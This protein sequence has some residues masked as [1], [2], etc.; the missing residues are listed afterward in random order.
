MRFQKKNIK[1]YTKCLRQAGQKSYRL[2]LETLESRYLL[3]AQP[4]TFD[5]ELGGIGGMDAQLTLMGDELQLLN[6]GS[7]V[8]SRALADT[9]KIVVLGSANADSLSIDASLPSGVPIE[10]DGRGG[11]D[12]LIGSP[13]FISWFLN[14]AG[15]GLVDGR[16]VFSNVENLDASSSPQSVLNYSSFANA[17]TVNL[18]TQSSTGLDSVVGFEGVIGSPFNDTITGSPADEIFTG[19]EGGDTIDGDGGEDILVEVRDADFT[20]TN[21]RLTVSGESPDTISDIEK[22]M[23]TGGPGNNRLDASSSS[24]V[25]ALDGADGDDE[26]LGGSANDSLTGGFG[27]DDINGGGGTDELVEFGDGRFV[28]TD[29]TLDVGHGSNEVQ[30]ISLGGSA[31]G[32]FR[33]TYE[34]KSTRSLTTD[35][36]AEGI[37]SALK[38]LAGIGEQDISVTAGVS[39]QQWSVEFRGNLAGS[40]V[41]ELLIDE[42]QLSN[43]TPVA[44]SDDGATA[45]EPFTAIEEVRLTGGSNNNQFDLHNYTGNVSVK[46]GEGDDTVVVGN[47]TFRLDGGLGIDILEAS[48]GNAVLK[49]AALDFGNGDFPAIGFERAMLFGS[50][51][52]DNLDATQFRGLSE[53]TWLTQLA[54]GNLGLVSGND[55][56]LNVNGESIELDLSNASMIGDVVKL[57]SE[58]SPAIS[59]TFDGENAR[60]VVSSTGDPATINFGSINGSAAAEG[61]GLAGG[62][63]DAGVLTGSQLLG[64]PSVKIQGLGGDDQIKGSPGNDF[65]T[66]NSGSDQITGGGGIDTFVESYAGISSAQFPTAT[67]TDTSFGTGLPQQ[68]GTDTLAGVSRADITLGQFASTF[69]A[70]GFTLGPVVV[71][72][73]GGADT[74]IGSPVGT[75]FDIDTMNL[76]AGETVTVRPDQAAANDVVIRTGNAIGQGDL[77]RVVYDPP[78][79]SVPVTLTNEGCEFLECLLPLTVASD[80]SAPGQDVTLRADVVQVFGGT[81]DTSD[82]T[83]AGNIAIK[84]HE[85]VLDGDATLRAKSA[86]GNDGKIELL[87]TD[88]GGFDFQGALKLDDSKATIIT[89]TTTIEGG[90]VT[91]ASTAKAENTAS[92]SFLKEYPLAKLTTLGFDQ[93]TGLIDGLSL[94]GAIARAEAFAQVEIGTNTVIH[95]NEFVASSSLVAAASTAPNSELFDQSSPA[96]IGIGLIETH[97]EIRVAGTI[98]ASGNATISS[99]V[100]QTADVLAEGN[101]N[102]LGLSV[103]ESDSIVEILD[104]AMLNVGSDLFVLADTVDHNRTASKAA[105]ADNP[106]Q[107][108]IAVSVE[109]G[110]TTLLFDG[111]ANVTGN[112]QASANQS[113]VG[114][115]ATN[116]LVGPISLP[117]INSGVTAASVVGPSSSKF[118]DNFIETSIQEVDEGTGFADFRH[119]FID[120]FTES[121]CAK[122]P[123]RLADLI[124]P[125]DGPAPDPPETPSVPSSLFGGALAIVVDTNNVRTR[126]GDGIVRPEVG[127]ADL[128]AGGMFAA[129]SKISNRPSVNATSSVGNLKL[130]DEKPPEQSGE[131]NSFAVSVGIFNNNADTIIESDADIDAVGSLTVRADTI[132]DFDPSSL[133]GPFNLPKVEDATYTTDSGSVTVNNGDTVDV[134]EGHKAADDNGGGNVGTRYKYAGTTRSIDLKTANFLDTGEWTLV[135]NPAGNAAKSFASSIATVLSSDLGLDSNVVDTWTQATAKGQTETR[136]GSAIVLSMNHDADAIVRDG[137]RINQDEAIA[138]GA[139]DVVV[140]ASS[141][142]ELIN[143]G[144]NISTPGL[145]GGGE[146]FQSWTL[147]T[148]FSGPGLGSSSDETFSAIGGAIMVFLYDDDV[149]ARIE[150]GAQVDAD[151][152]YVDA[153]NTALAVTF[154]AAGGESMDSAY[155]GVV[156]ANSIDN[157]TIAQVGSGA[158][159][160]IRSKNVN[161]GADRGAPLVIEATDQA[162]VVAI[163]GAVSIS[164]HIGVGATVGMNFVTRDTEAILG[165]RGATAPTTLG[166][167]NVA[168]NTSVLATND[169]FVGALAVSGAKTGSSG[170]MSSGKTGVSDRNGNNV[171]NPGSLPTDSGESY[172]DILGDIHNLFEEAP[173]VTNQG[174]AG[175]GISGSVTLNVLNQ[176]A[177][178]VVRNTGAITTQD[179]NVHGTDESIV[180]SLAG[181]ATFASGGGTGGGGGKGISGALGLNFMGGTTEAIVDATS[182]INAANLDIHAM[183]DGWVVSLT[184]GVAGAS[185][186]G[187][188]A[189]GG[190]VS[191]TRTTNE[192]NALL[193]DTNGAVTG[194]AKVHAMDA[195]NVI[196]IAGSAGFGSRG[197]IGAAAGFSELD[198][199]VSAE[200]VNVGTEENPFTFNDL[201][202]TAE[203]TG[204][205][206]SVTGS[207][208]VATNG[209][210]VG[211]TLSINVIGNEIGA[212]VRNSHLTSTAGDISVLATDD[213]SIFSFAGGLAAG[214]TAGLGLAAAINFL[215]NQVTVDM[216]DSVVRGG[217]AFRVESKQTGMIVSIAVGGALANNI[218][219]GGAVAVNKTNNT[220]RNNLGDSIVVVGGIIDVAAQDQTASVNIAGGAAI[221]GKAALGVGVSVNL[222]GNTIETLV[223]G[224]KLESTGST[225]TVRS[226]T[227]EI[228]VGV[229]VG[230]SG[231][232]TAALAGSVS[233]NQISNTVNTKVHNNSDLDASGN[234]VISAGDSTTMVVVAGAGALGGTAGF[235]AAVGTTQVDNQIFA[236]IDGSAVDSTG[237]SVQ[238]LAGFEAPDSDRDV[239]QIGVG[240]AGHGIQDP[241]QAGK[242]DGDDEPLLTST[243]SHIIN[244]AVA[245][246]AAGT[247]AGGA[248]INLNWLKNHV[249]ASIINGATVNGKNGVDVLANDNPEIISIAIGVA[250]AGTGAGGGAISYNYIGGNPGNP[251]R[252]VPAIPASK[253]VGQVRA[254]IANSTVSSSDD[255]VDVKTL[256][257]P[258]IINVSVGVAAAGAA[259]VGGSIS[260]N[261][262]R[263]I[264]EARIADSTVNAQT[265]A[266]VD[267][268]VSPSMIIVAGSGAGSG[269]AAAAGAAATNDMRNDVMAK[270]ENSTVKVASDAGNLQVHATVGPRT[271]LSA[272]NNRVRLN[273]QDEDGNQRQIDTQIWSFAVSG[274]GA[275]GAAAAG[276]LALNWIRNTV[277]AH[278]SGGDTHEIESTNVSVAAADQASIKSVAGAGSGAGGAAVG[279]SVA[280]NYIGGNPEDPTS[281]ERNTVIA[282]IHGVKVIAPTV[283]VLADSVS[284]INT[285]SI[286]GAGAGGV[287]ASGGLSLNFIRTTLDAH[288]SDGA[289]VN[290]TGDIIVQAQDESTIESLSVAGAVA[291]GLGAGAAAAYNEIQ[292]NV[293]ATIG[294]S[295]IDGGHN[296]FVHALSTPTIDVIVAGLGV[297]AVGLA[298][299]GS[300]NKMRSDVRASVDGADVNVANDTHVIGF[301]NNNLL[302]K[303]GAFAGGVGAG[304]GTVVVNDV[305][306]ETRAFINNSTVKA[307]GDHGVAK[308][309]IEADL[310][311]DGV[312]DAGVK[313]LTVFANG[314]FAE[315]SDDNVAFSGALGAAG[316]FAGNVVVN[317]LNDVTEA[318]INDSKVNSAED[319][320]EGV[321]VLASYNARPE[322]KVG[323]AASG[324]G[325]AIGASVDTFIVG[326]KTRAFIDDHDGTASG[327]DDRT[328]IHAKNSVQVLARSR[329]DADTA[330]IGAAIAG[331]GAVAGAAN[332]MDLDT[333]TEA[334]IRDSVI[335]ATGESVGVATGKKGVLVDATDYVQIDLLVG[336][337]SA[338]ALGSGS[339]SVAAVTMDN[340][341]HSFLEGVDIE[342]PEDVDMRAFPTST[343]NLT[344]GTLAVAAGKGLAATVGVV[345]IGGKTSATLQSSNDFESKV[346]AKSYRSSA[347]PIINVRDKL[348]TL[349]AGLGAGLGATADVILV[350]TSTDSS[351]GSGVEVTATENI[352]LHADNLKD[353]STIITAFAGGLKAGINGSLSVIS[354][355]AGLTDDGRDEADNMQGNVN[356]TLQRDS[357][358]SGMQPRSNVSAGSGIHAKTY[359][360]NAETDIKSANMTAAQSQSVDNA[361]SDKQHEGTVAS[362]ASGAKVSSANLDVLSEDETKVVL[363]IGQATVGG[364]A[365]VGGS[366]GIISTGTVAESYIGENAEVK[367]TGDIVVKADQKSNVDAEALAGTVGLVGL[368]AQFITID[369]DG[370]AKASINNGTKIDAK[371][372]KVTA[373]VDRILDADAS[374]VTVGAV[375]AGAA[376]SEVAAGGGAYAW[377]G[378]NAVIGA[379]SPVSMVVL[380]ATDLTRAKANTLAVAAGIGAG[381]A[382]IADATI[383][384]T[385]TSAINTGASTNAGTLTVLAKATPKA[386]TDSQGVTVGGVALGLSE[387][388]A[389]VSP[390]VDAHVGG[391]V[392]ADTLSVQAILND[393][394]NSTAKAAS[395]GA[396]TAQYSNWGCQDRGEC[397]E[398]HCQ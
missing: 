234:V 333:T 165:D 36:T 21:T 262:N 19:A 129:T 140:A 369:D 380:S 90:D 8:A 222:I 334:F 159:L 236:T 299:S 186:R 230:G 131:G 73:I 348:G 74:L 221:A 33:L 94:G 301:T 99:R 300:G 167:V 133:R 86:S 216:N 344:A 391:E 100:D 364:I 197:G 273:G 161:D 395:A 139:Q 385:V 183:R 7:V 281:D 175:I 394:V 227:D 190:S 266:I 166:T 170:G 117:T 209:T 307:R 144:G 192:T 148:T 155:N 393:Q 83:R 278:I 373:D 55:L 304:A 305:R 229:A 353:I 153:A 132:N 201:M 290:T 42:T 81:I 214:K 17:V 340:E 34:G 286:V 194:S 292:N 56:Q 37:E 232:G 270:V 128:D 389:I 354:V 390:T 274:A 145:Q 335:R 204:L 306:N 123:M 169:G 80:I 43:A 362:I 279:L 244:V 143:L 195:T 89:G 225:I 30:M 146:R 50:P 297:G 113:K 5:A 124:C 311:G 4:L 32:F 383:E 6:A 337:A 150:D 359:R 296:L 127:R 160:N 206:V 77:G 265:E 95:A 35:V 295:M 104:T 309:R 45:M 23:L 241:A 156:M 84:A 76:P 106:D 378:D 164:D 92:K 67:L 293:H 108:G 374:G 326:L 233:V 12:T 291:G 347:L 142:N 22:V 13:T 122:V 66:G 203:A 137:A 319:Q 310:D 114:I 69:D 41:G 294:E 308:L 349:A 64:S 323:A 157:S 126:I 40:D 149:V 60:F 289:Q 181:A 356:N 352:V 272:L 271:D 382:N 277:D 152:L 313:G 176:D 253:N 82:P 29:T 24:I 257:D 177:R 321:S 53:T 367:S 205:I 329:F 72:S 316:G 179:L 357:L 256:S 174:Q 49:N 154:G 252:E 191:V 70:S 189:V 282:Y 302:T 11:S 58:A 372:L 9:S 78:T 263:N 101:G 79:S 1:R 178:A 138:H 248:A 103:I 14:D 255:G 180:A 47:N 251:S 324:G 250:A 375:A 247:F 98:N 346:V 336:A 392:N 46:A 211:G 116:D 317:L 39:A 26:L 65:L 38:R 371:T 85:I 105:A 366:A 62:S 397:K 243:G 219:V 259:A 318:S 228:L 115:A 119:E 207:V 258:T 260:I 388:D 130:D 338:A 339:G 315:R 226:S 88:I 52:A 370:E 215:S 342:T 285:A 387:T 365:S 235:G 112:I 2:G 87:A 358:G 242:T 261:F 331:L 187:S 163:A 102:A 185:G 10:F 196:L 147:D 173:D 48:G 120:V 125:D 109:H 224:S 25:V 345:D 363:F 20:L 184:A 332:A 28:L 18:A 54:S 330:T 91:I 275:G 327:E 171:S 134:K 158:T 44:T 213:S 210:A 61:L 314:L 239:S 220:I 377:I 218:A 182:S 16:T 350:N 396:A 343:V 51:Q 245:G 341:L 298:G 355:G 360:N 168:G 268:R 93:I 312:L 237:G 288:I 217:G 231:A 276:S 141:I 280:Y 376:I 351:I 27:N 386:T 200:I 303:T 238:V 57:L 322:N 269:G 97:A 135:G 264:V 121:A 267:A 198:N 111:T 212:A 107:I 202:V 398:L 63:L 162:D 199:K 172:D 240:A 110:D 151:S 249:E 328:T 384:S 193:K 320:G 246:A 287:A 361:F 96:T 118:V 325:V 75:T 136:A 283:E 223:S 188:I 68:S 254:I 208:G 284:S 368:G 59:A 15:S 381:T 31:T 379:E 71:R 3:T